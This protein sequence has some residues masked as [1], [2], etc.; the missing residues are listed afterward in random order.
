VIVSS[1]GL[2]RWVAATLLG[3]GAGALAMPASAP[4]QAPGIVQLSATDVALLNGVRLA[5]LWEIPAGSMAAQKGRLA[6]VRRIGAEISKQHVELDQLVVEAANK[7]GAQLPDQPT[8]EQKGWLD[9]M[10]NSAGDRFDRIFVDRLRAAHGKIFPVIGAVR[11]GTRNEV[12]RKLAMDANTFVNDHMIMLEGTG[13]VRYADL[14]PAAVPPPQDEGRLA[15]SRANAGLSASISP[16]ASW[17]V[18]AIALVLCAMAA[19]RI[20]R[21][22]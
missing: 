2:R 9:E 14:P 16:M 18:I 5:G 11:A 17:I 19:F 6:E 4:A 1:V 22:R 8:A 3:L 20:V 12:I 13:L 7:L 15:I 10:Q 21:R